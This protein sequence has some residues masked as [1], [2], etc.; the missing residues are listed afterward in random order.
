LKKNIVLVIP[1]LQAGGMERVM[2]EVAN[3]LVK[4]PNY[5]VKLV[6]YG[7]TREVFYEVDPRIPI[8]KPDF[9]FN[10]QRRF[11]STIK[12]LWFLRKTLKELG[13][14]R[15]LSFGELWNNF[16]MLAVLGTG[17]EVV[18][19]D[20]SQPDKSLGG[21][22]ERLRKFLYPKSYGIIAQTTKA[23]EI[24]TRLYHHKNIKVI[25]NPIREIRPNEG[26]KRENVIVSV[27]RLI[28]S[29]NHDALIRIFA[30]LQRAEDWKLIIVGYD[31]LKQKNQ[32]LLEA[33]AKELKVEDRV[34]FAGKQKDVESYYLRSKIFAFT[35]S[36]EGFPNVLGEAMSAGLPVI[37]YDCVAGPSDL[38]DNQVNGFLIPL[39][40]DKLYLEK[41]Q[42]MIDNPALLEQMSVQSL[43][44]IK[45][46]SPEGICR[47]F[48]EFLLSDYQLARK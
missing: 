42:A 21:F 12:T 13:P 6:L 30:K 22:H 17:I 11:L 28:K 3:Y 1:S 27:G 36:S 34:I 45:E 7:I 43:K 26:I 44:K 33:L 19:S 20:R 24:Y 46:F 25:G 31:H 48:E 4:K 40:E 9:V 16:V 18:L 38:I 39:F 5:D 35:S 32:V 23:F 14:D 37:S 2:T 41:L 29:K 10:N 47:K 15:V 8:I